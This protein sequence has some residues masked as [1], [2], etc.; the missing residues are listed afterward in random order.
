M[1]AELKKYSVQEIC[2]GFVY[3]ELEEKGLY[4]LSGKLT[5]QPEYQ[6][7]YIYKEEKKDEAVIQSV[8]L[9]YPLG[10]IYF[11]KK[12]DGHLEVLDGQQ[13]ITS[14][15]RYL[16]NKFAIT[17]NDGMQ[18]IFHGL[19]DEEKNR[20]Q[21]TMLLVYVCEGSEKE[22]KKWFETINIV[23]I[24]L[25]NQERL[26]AFYSGNFVN[27]AKSEF[28]NSKNPLIQKWECYIRG[29]AI[30]Q[31]ILERA[32]DWVSKGDIEG[33]MSRNRNNNDISELKNYF[34]SVI[35][36]VSS[37]FIDIEKEM[38]GV[39]WGRLYEEYH[40]KS[41]NPSEVSKQ[42]RNLYDDNYVIKKKGIF[43]YILGDGSDTKLL[44][45]R[46]FGDSIKKSVYSKQ[47][48]EA[49]SK[50]ISNCPLCCEGHEKV[51]NKIW[52]YSEMD[53]D[54]VTA[55]ANGGSTDIDNCQMLCKTHN[56]VKGNL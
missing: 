25:S 12:K 50:G 32:L 38:K 2:Q 42:L 37:V 44:E 1:K 8:L 16:N 36:W 49:K 26:N 6:R 33:Y 39:E 7:N 31:E 27:L 40:K 54:H 29:K 18:Q 15:G 30:R 55:W 48:A 4:G 23:G 21:N 28:S 51:K 24:E 41:F 13:R 56:R 22:I 11:N 47:T 46:L 3:N 10:L 17:D 34:N 53:A 19:N 52:K 9:E 5:I 14:L 45:I 43:E 20:I 35:D